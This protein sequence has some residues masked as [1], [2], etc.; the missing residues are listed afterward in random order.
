MSRFYFS[1]TL[2]VLNL[3]TFASAATVNFSKIEQNSYKK[4]LDKGKCKENKQYER[5]AAINVNAEKI[6]S[7]AP[8][9]RNKG[10]KEGQVLPRGATAL[11]KR[12]L[13]NKGTPM[14][15]NSV[16]STPIRNSQKDFD[17]SYNLVP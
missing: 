1:S 11:E 8:D 5:L 6:P 17:R 3:V 4:A 2:F 13:Y 14:V 9:L 16:H 15:K 7:N 10:K 12:M